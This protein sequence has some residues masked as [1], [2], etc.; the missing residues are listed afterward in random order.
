MRARATVNNTQKLTLVPTEK[1]ETIKLSS[2]MTNGNQTN[3][4][5]EML[6]HY[7]FLKLCSCKT[8]QTF[9]G[10][11]SIMS[12]FS[13]IRRW[14]KQ[15]IYFANMIMASYTA[16]WKHF[17][18]L[19]WCT[20]AWLFFHILAKCINTH[21]WKWKNATDFIKSLLVQVCMCTAFML[22]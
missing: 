22:P 10:V 15:N 20:M 12:K 14:F 18:K 7:G 8:V 1:R 17:E 19:V 13:F 6:M 21:I 16:I 3:T 5:M 2:V 11:Y 4:L 9:N